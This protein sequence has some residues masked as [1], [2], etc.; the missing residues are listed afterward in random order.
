MAD[1]KYMPELEA[2]P[3]AEV[4]KIID[5]KAQEMKNN[6]INSRN[7]IPR[8]ERV[9]YVSNAGCDENDGLS[10]E[11]PICSIEKLNSI[12]QDRDTVLFKRGDM[13][14]GSVKVVHDNLTFYAYGEGIKP[15]I[16]GSLKNYADPKLWEATEYE[17][18]YR[19]TELLDNVGII[20]FDPSYCYG[21]Y[22]DLYADKALR[23]KNGFMELSDLCDDLFFQRQRNERAVPLLA[24]GKPRR[25]FY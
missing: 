3:P 7:Y 19:C 18:V 1:R 17:N 9:I 22:D 20:A 5:L 2:L 6:V 21:S 11:K 8:G 16:S 14:R 4:R 12:T 13:F 25:A 15:I 23:G 10:I 24:Q